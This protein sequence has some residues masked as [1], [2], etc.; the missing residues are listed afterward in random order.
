M[1][2]SQYEKEQADKKLLV[3]KLDNL[4]DGFFTKGVEVELLQETKDHYQFSVKSLKDN[5]WFYVTHYKQP[6]DYVLFKIKFEGKE[7][8]IEST[9]SAKDKMLNVWHKIYGIHNENYKWNVDKK[10]G[11]KIKKSPDSFQ[12]LFGEQPR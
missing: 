10:G 5:K 9:D 3:K 2:F 8:D 4:I 6:K 7:T 11:E 1:S 12:R